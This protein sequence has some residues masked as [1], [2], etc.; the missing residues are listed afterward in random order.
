MGYIKKITSLI[1]AS[2]DGISNPISPLQLPHHCEYKSKCSVH[3]ARSL[4]SLGISSSLG[5]STST[6][7]QRQDGLGDIGS[8]AGIS[9]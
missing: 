1:Y 4:G 6:Q 8:H 5:S 7:P 9:I 3:P 2:S